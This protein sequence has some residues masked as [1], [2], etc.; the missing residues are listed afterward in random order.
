[1][2]DYSLGENLNAGNTESDSKLL[3]N[4]LQSGDGVMV[5]EQMQHGQ[6]LPVWQA[7]VPSSLCCIVK[8]TIGRRNT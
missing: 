3:Q 6:H 1:M 4:I 2:P 8:V 5:D 7:G